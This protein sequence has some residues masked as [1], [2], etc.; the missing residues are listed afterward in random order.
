V[1]GMNAEVIAAISAV[2][3]AAP[4]VMIAT[5][6]IIAATLSPKRKRFGNPGSPNCARRGVY[7]GLP[8]ALLLAS[9][10]NVL[11]RLR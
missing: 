1:P 10:T 3:R 2:P 6:I 11:R 7:Q 8:D 5:R 4:P 9:R